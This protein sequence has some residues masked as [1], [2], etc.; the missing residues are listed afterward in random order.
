MGRTAVALVAA[1]GLTGCA[2]TEFEED[3]RSQKEL[4]N[5]VYET[6]LQRGDMTQYE[7]AA[8][9]NDNR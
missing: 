5:E 8:Q 4:A 7:C 2:S 1:L 6:C 3:N 9:A